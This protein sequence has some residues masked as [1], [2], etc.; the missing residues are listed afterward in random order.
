MLAPAAEFSGVVEMSDMPTFGYAVYPIDGKRT[1][2]VTSTQF[3]QDL[4]SSIVRNLG[5]ATAMQDSN[6]DLVQIVLRVPFSET[7]EEGK[8]ATLILKYD[9]PGAI[10]PSNLR[11]DVLLESGDKVLQLRT[12]ANPAENPTAATFFDV[13]VPCDQLRNINGLGEN[14]DLQVG[15]SPYITP[16]A[17]AEGNAEVNIDEQAEVFIGFKE[18]AETW[19]EDLSQAR[20]LVNVFNSS[21]Q[22][23]ADY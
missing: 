3:L 14:V 19:T 10:I 20:V 4:V 8:A 6:Y 5:A 1:A 15:V 21:N 17:D 18:D 23:F 13:P 2:V 7:S 16:T 22:L 9:G 12:T 11:L